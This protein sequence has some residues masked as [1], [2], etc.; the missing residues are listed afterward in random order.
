MLVPM[1]PPARRGAAPRPGLAMRELSRAT[2]LPRSTLLHYLAE[3]LLPAPA[4]SSRNMAWY[5]PSCVERVKLVRQLQQHHRLALHEIRA[6]LAREDPAALATRLA[7]NE[8]VFGA[9]ERAA[10]GAGAFAAETG[11]S[12]AALRALLRLGLLAPLEPEHFDDADVAAGR[13]LARALG[14]GL[15]PADLSFYVRAAEAVVEAQM[16]I[17]RRLTAHVSQADNAALTLEMLA[18]GRV[19]RSYVMERTFQRRVAAMRSL[20]DRGARVARDSRRKP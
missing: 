5:D 19:V 1:T 10:L 20:E 7:L 8:A 11:L 18:S 15:S 14:L 17:R 12:P 3:G 2:G 9:G 4:R 6:L 13:S 16:A